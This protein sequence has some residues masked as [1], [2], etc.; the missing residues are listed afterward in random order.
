MRIFSI[1]YFFAILSYAQAQEVIINGSIKNNKDSTV[2][3]IQNSL[4]AITG[5]MNFINHI[6]KIDSIGN[7]QIT[8]PIKRITR[9]MLEVDNQQAFFHLS[10]NK[11]ISILIDLKDGNLDFKAIGENAEYVNFHNILIDEYYK[12]LPKS[13]DKDLKQLETSEYLREQKVNAQKIQIILD[14]YTKNTDFD[15]EF[16]KWL[17]SFYKYYPYERTLQSKLVGNPNISDS[18]INE[19]LIS[20]GLTD[21]YAALNIREYNILANQYAHYKFNGKKFP[22]DLSK[23]ASYISESNILTGKTKEVCNR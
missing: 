1:I 23:M 9:W 14:N 15:P 22:L 13:Y 10:P 20:E 2:I 18:L 7:F 8:L 19:L 12:K 16:Y 4:D 11:N 6:A 17:N 5:E 21:D 3:F